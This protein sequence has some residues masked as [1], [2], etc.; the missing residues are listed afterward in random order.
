LFQMIYFTRK[1]PFENLNYNIFHIIA[2]S[3]QFLIFLLLAFIDYSVKKMSIFIF[4]I[5]LLHSL[6]FIFLNIYEI[7]LFLL[8][9]FQKHRKSIKKALPSENNRL[10]HNEKSEIIEIHENFY[11]EPVQ[12]SREVPLRN[13][14]SFIQLDL[15]FS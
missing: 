8:Q 12:S 2:T 9:F 14:L 3:N 6:S 10:N 11:T 7:T 15:S 5:S 1:L 13:C 4:A